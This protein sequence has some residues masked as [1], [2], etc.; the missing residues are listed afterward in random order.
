[1]KAVLFDLDG[2]LTDTFELW[3]HS[4]ASLVKK[5]TEKKLSKEEYEQKYWGADSRTKIR[6]LI[7]E[8]PERVEKLYAELQKL[9][10]DNIKLVKTFPGVN[11]TL[12]ALSENYRL[13]VISNSS[14]KFLEAQLK[15]TGTMKYFSAKIADAEPKPSPDGILKACRELGVQVSQAVFVGDSQYDVG[16]G[17]NAGIRTIIIGRDIDII[18]SLTEAI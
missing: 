10:L 5:H 1:M 12:K 6:K 17:K 2:T 11:E 14:M 18:A 15:Q 16:A 13:A 8:E 7:T 3:Y 9:L 4:V